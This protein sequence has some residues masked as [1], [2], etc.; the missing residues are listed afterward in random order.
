MMGEGRPMDPAPLSFDIVRDG[1]TLVVTPLRDM[2]ELEYAQIESGAKDLFDRLRDPAIKNVVLDFRETD[3]YGSTA[4]GFFVKLWKRVCTQKNGQ[5]AFCN[6]S[7]HEMEILN[8]TK[9]SKLWPI[10][11]SRDAALAVVRA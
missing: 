10:C 7:P 6:V 8:I 3:A 2:G 11:P 4:L 5:L 1:D 9:L